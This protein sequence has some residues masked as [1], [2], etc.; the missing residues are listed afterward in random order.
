MQELIYYSAMTYSDTIPF[1]IILAL[2]MFILAIVTSGLVAQ[3]TEALEEKNHY[4]GKRMPQK[5]YKIF[6]KTLF[7][8]FPFPKMLQDCPLI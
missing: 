2:A 7:Y 6:L 4:L 1:V 5:G 8:T 3:E